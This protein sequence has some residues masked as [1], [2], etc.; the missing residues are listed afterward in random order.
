MCLTAGHALLRFAL[1][2]PSS[3]LQGLSAPL[4]QCAFKSTS[5]PFIQDNQ[6]ALLWEASTAYCIGK[7]F[8]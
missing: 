8:H 1:H 3:S 7:G 5:F 2:L 6:Q 4:N